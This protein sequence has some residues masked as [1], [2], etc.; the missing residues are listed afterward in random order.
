MDLCRCDKRQQV[1]RKAL[2]LTSDGF[3]RS[4]TSTRCPKASRLGPLQ[5]THDC[6]HE[7]APGH[8]QIE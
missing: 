8:T 3:F 2:R 7:Q 1:S 4:T 5:R 6:I